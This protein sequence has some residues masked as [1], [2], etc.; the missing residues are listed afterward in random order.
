MSSTAMAHA[1]T[2]PKSATCLDVIVI[3]AGFSGMHALYSL[4]AHGLKV[5]V[6]DEGHT[7]GGTWNWNRYPGARVDFPVAP[8][9]CYTFS[10][11]L[12]NEFD[13]PE[14]QPDQATVLKYLNF[15]ADRMD[16]RRDIELGTRI[17]G[18]T[19]DEASQRW[20]VD[21]ST[22]AQVEAQF[23]IC[24]SGALSAAN[25]PNIPGIKTFAGDCYHTG[26]WPQDPKV[27]FTGKRVAV[28]GTGSSGVQSIPLIARECKHLTVLQRTPQ[29]TVPAGNRPV[30]PAFVANARATWPDIKRRMRVTP[31]GSPFIASTIRAMEHTP[32][33]RREVYERFWQEGGFNIVIDTYC[34]LFTDKA[35]NDTLSEFVREKIRGIVKNPDTAQKLLPNYLL[36]TKRQ[37]LDDGYYDTFNRD[38][39]TL[40]DLREDPIVEF[41]P[42]GVRTKT[43]DHRLDTLVL[44]TG[45]D[46]ITGTLQRLNPRGRG[47]VTLN[48]RWKARFNSYLGITIP[49]FPN[50]FMVHGPESPGVLFNMPL[51]AEMEN[52]WIRDCI[53]HVRAQGQG[54]VEPAP[55]VD[56]AWGEEVAAHAHQTLFEQTESW[57]TGANIAGKHRQFAVHVAGPQYFAK[58][59]EVAAQ[60]YPGFVFEP[61]F[62]AKSAGA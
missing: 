38:N 52:D 55:G 6:Y 57:Y 44:A 24:A 19:Y 62:M 17:T 8:Y 23:L 32:E 51:G 4:R 43:G 33:Q 27:D 26:R 20:R 11:E 10:D 12:M 9:Y 45:F 53:L 29:Y 1:T 39:V 21:T 59:G 60:G 54:A 28:L 61:A 16:L 47:G 13:W 58:L 15:V 49:G 3:G 7:V 25:S 40:V 42:G 22:G 5:R 37:V 34:D 48:E 46:A 56:V 18:A 50:L 36:G 35:A 30:D 41:Y 31:F 14:R 2:A